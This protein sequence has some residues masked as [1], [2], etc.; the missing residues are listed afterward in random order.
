MAAT[1]TTKADDGE[2]LQSLFANYCDQD[3]L[4]T[5]ET[6]ATQI[7]AIRELLVCVCYFMLLCC[8][9]CVHLFINGCAGIVQYV[10]TVLSKLYGI[11]CLSCEGY[12]MHAP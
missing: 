1:E 5:K 11:I 9:E 4:M 2:A 10:F 8:F 6:L 12:G 7:S 3:G